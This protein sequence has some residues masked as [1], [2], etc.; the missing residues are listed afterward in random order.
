MYTGPFS[1]PLCARQP[2][3][4]I[5]RT[6]NLLTN[7]RS[8]TGRVQLNA[9]FRPYLRWWQV[10]LPKRNGTFAFLETHWSGPEVLQLY[11]DAAIFQ[12]FRGYFQG[13][14]FQSCWPNWFEK[15][16][17]GIELLEMM[18]VMV[19]CSVWRTSCI[20]R[21]YYSIAII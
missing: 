9:E 2:G 8:C 3:G 18:P 15:F 13:R 6:I 1:L 12:G 7:S 10:Y 16:C 11:N 21:R 5:R 17:P 4:Y 20:G 14:L 19:V